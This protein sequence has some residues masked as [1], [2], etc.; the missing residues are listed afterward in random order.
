MD[1]TSGLRLEQAMNRLLQFT[2]DV[3]EGTA[4]FAQKR[5]GQVE[6]RLRRCNRHRFDGDTGQLQAPS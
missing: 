1:L 6:P 2:H 4:A 5:N 3:E